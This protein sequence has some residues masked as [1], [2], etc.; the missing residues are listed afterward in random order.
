MVVKDWSDEVSV[1]QSLCLFEEGKV[2]VTYTAIGIP[3]LFP[4]FDT[5]YSFIEPRNS[6]S[7]NNNFCLQRGVI[8]K[9]YLYSDRLRQRS[10]ERGFICIRIDFDAA[11]PSVFTTPIETVIETAS[12]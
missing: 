6:G 10:H 1:V 7:H 12:I 3:H 2:L 5:L 4:I 8:N 9:I 11:T